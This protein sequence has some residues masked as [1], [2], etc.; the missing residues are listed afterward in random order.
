MLT[1]EEN[2]I[3]TRVEPGTPGGELLRRYSPPAPRRPEPFLNPDHL[4]KAVES[5]NSG[6]SHNDFHN[7]PSLQKKAKRA[8]VL[9]SQGRRS[10]G[11][12]RRVGLKI[13]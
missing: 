5:L 8:K 13:Q 6:K 10:G 1:K 3:L 7:T 12:G 11:T 9:I 4:R 2:D